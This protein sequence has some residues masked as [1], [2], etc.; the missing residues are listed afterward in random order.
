MKKL[1]LGLLLLPSLAL[2]DVPP[3]AKLY[4]PVLKQQLKEVW[5]ALNLQSSVAADIEQESCISLT[6]SRCWDPKAELKTSREYGFGLGQITIAYDKNGKVRFNNFNEMK[7]LDS[8]LKSWKWEDRYNPS[9]QIRAMVVM[10]HN[11]YIK[12]KFPTSNEYEKMAFTYSAYNGGLGGVLQDE[13][14]CQSTRGCDPKKWFGNVEKH[15]FKQKTKVSGY[16]KSFFDI[17][18]EYVKN[19][20]IVRRPKYIP[21]F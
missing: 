12:L 1:L 5:P 7:K 16:G 4:I 15:S 18:R 13:K 10:H 21:Y 3:K 9:Y 8:K 14:L 11:N 2:A 20:M 17:N 6:S 19:V